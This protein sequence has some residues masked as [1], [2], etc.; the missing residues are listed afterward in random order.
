MADYIVGR[1]P[2]LE[3]LKAGQPIEKITVQHGTHGSAIDSIYKLAKQNGIPVTQASKERFRELSLEKNTQGVIAVAGAKA[4][5][6]LEDILAVAQSR[7]EPAFILIL[8]EIE[9]PQNL[10][11]LIRTAECAGTHGVVIP[12][13][14]AAT[15]N[16][17]V[18]KTSAGAAAH[19]AIARVP[20]IVHALEALKR[21]G[22]WIIGADM[23]AKGL[24]YQADFKGPVGIVIGNEGRGLRRLVKENCDFL[25]SIP[26]FGKLQSLNA[27]VAGGLMLY[28]VAK[29]RHAAER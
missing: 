13:H 12:K 9:D 17:T 22:T 16:D 2:V 14:H 1:Q 21:S 15:V 27:S 10:G 5:A 18:M 4:Y 11:A 7:N 3:A 6:E 25:V 20:N 23:D 26:L 19:I 29:Q 28:E 8:D 24:Y